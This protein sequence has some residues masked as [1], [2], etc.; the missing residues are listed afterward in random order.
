MSLKDR[1]LQP[2]VGESGISRQYYGGVSSQGSSQRSLLKSRQSHSWSIGGAGLSSTSFPTALDDVAG[3]ALNPDEMD[4]EGGVYPTVKGKGHR[5]NSIYFESYGWSHTILG[6]VSFVLQFDYYCI[7]STAY[8][9]VVEIAGDERPTPA[10]NEYYGWIA[11]AFAIAAL[12]GAPIFGAWSDRRGAKEAVVVGCLLMAV[13]NVVYFLRLQELH[14]LLIARIISG[15]GSASRVACLGYI[16]KTTE[17][18]TRGAKIG[19][20]YQYGFLG[21]VLGPA[22]GSAFSALKYEPVKLLSFGPQ[23]SPALISFVF[24]IIICFI[25]GRSLKPIS[26]ELLDLQKNNAEIGKSED[27]V[28]RKSSLPCGNYVLIFTQF[29]LMLCISTFE[30]LVIPMLSKRFDWGQQDGT[31]ILMAIGLLII[32]FNALAVCLK[33]PRCNCRDH[34]V[35][36]LGVSLFL[37]G[38]LF[39]LDWNP[40][41]SGCSLL[42]VSQVPPH[43]PRDITVFSDAENIAFEFVSTFFVALGFTFAFVTLPGLFVHIIITKGGEHMIPKIGKYMALLSIAGSVAKVYG[44]LIIGY[45]LRFTSNLLVLSIGG[46]VALV[47]IT[48]LATW[49]NL[50]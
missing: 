27:I 50:H 26:A 14:W 49:R 8:Y 45:G 39:S 48:W 35:A 21:M 10:T 4:E 18:S 37:F 13:G 29:A 17:G 43:C 3:E 15:L 25:I 11:S 12:V 30:T 34:V 44:P 40:L 41:L 28:V 6:F 20:F 32:P 9:R 24:D 23:N 22:L 5:S 46:M 33:G 7:A 36:F 1:L 19:K 47:I 16:S 2:P 31:L 38:I 42:N